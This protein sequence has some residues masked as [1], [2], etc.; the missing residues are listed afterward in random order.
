MNNARKGLKR[1]GLRAY[2]IGG[3]RPMIIERI[4]RRHFAVRPQD[5][6]SSFCYQDFR[7]LRD[8]RAA[9]EDWAK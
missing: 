7:L 5:M 4:K 8:A 3:K 6:P 9:A 2:R 1:Y